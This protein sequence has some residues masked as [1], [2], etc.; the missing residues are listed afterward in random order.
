LSQSGARYAAGVA[1]SA[2][3]AAAWTFSDTKQQQTL[4]LI[5][6]THDQILGFLSCD[7]LGFSDFTSSGTAGWAALP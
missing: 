3:L 7:F 6:L 5:P 2:V 1:A 4:A